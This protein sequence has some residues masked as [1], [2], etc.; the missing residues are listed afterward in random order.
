[1][2]VGPDGH[3]YLLTDVPNGAILKLQPAG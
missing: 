1:V 3:V 2:R